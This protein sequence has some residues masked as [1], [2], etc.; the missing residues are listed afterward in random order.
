MLGTFVKVFGLSF[1]IGLSIGYIG[2]LCLKKLKAYNIGIT[3]GISENE[4]GNGEIT[5]EQ[6]ATML[7]RTLKIAG[8]NVSF[9]LNSTA[10]FADDGDI[11]DWAKESVYYMASRGIIRGVG[12]NTFNSLGNAKVEEALLV[13]LRCVK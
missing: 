11:D 9:D 10:K 7:A 8:I 2:S 3:L 13:A 6:M 4:F 5:R 12:D 1:F